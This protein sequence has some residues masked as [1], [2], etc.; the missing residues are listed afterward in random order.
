MRFN[1]LA[2]QQRHIRADLEARIKTVLDHNMYIHGPEVAEL[3]ERLARFAGAKHCVGCASGTDALFIALLTWGVGPGQAVFVPSFTFFATAEAVALLGATPIMVDIDPVT[4]NMD[5]GSLEKALAAVKARDASLYPLPRQ[6]RENQLK[7]TAVIFVDL[8]GQPADYEALL[9]LAKKHGLMTLE[10]AA[11]AFGAEYRGQRTCALGCDA[12]ATSFFPAKP[13]G[14][15][16]DG[17]ALFTDD[18]ALA[19]LFRSIIY[20]GKGRDRYEHV[21]LGVNGR[22]DTMQAAVLLS[23]LEIFPGEIQARQRVA[24]AYTRALAALPGLTP[25]RIAPACLSVWAQYCILVSGGRPRR[26]ALAARLAEKDIPTSIF[27][28]APLHLVEAFQYLEYASEDLPVSRT[29]SGD[30]L[31]LPFHPYLTEEE[32]A[33]VTLA[34]AEALG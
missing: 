13:L 16:G 25:P 32:M 6:A 10:D 19:E 30:I 18:G 17:G 29:R 11:Q 8:F 24:Q 31:A 3:E 20:H 33:R 15:Y 12:G 2:A 14:A 26:D 4:F 5:P 7:P 28:P 1:D 34:V 23:K 22:L 27:Y 9:P 21:R